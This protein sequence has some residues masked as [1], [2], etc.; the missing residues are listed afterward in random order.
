MSRKLTDDEKKV[1]W[2]WARWAAESVREYLELHDV[3]RID[4]EGFLDLATD[5]L[6][7]IAQA[8][9]MRTQKP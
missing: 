3:E 7:D 5:C 9:A 4:E 8:N 6:N 2:A 1:C